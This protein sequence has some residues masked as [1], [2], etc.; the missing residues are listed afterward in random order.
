MHGSPPAL[1]HGAP[2]TAPR[3]DLCWV[4]PGDAP[5]AIAAGLVHGTV[6]AAYRFT[7]FRPSPSEPSRA[8][9]RAG[10]GARCVQRLASSS[11]HRETSR[12]AS[13]A[14]VVAE[15]QNRAR[16][17]GNRPPNDLTPT[18]LADYA[19]E[20]A[21]RHPAL[22]VSVLD[23][24]AIRELGMG[25]FAAVAQG[26]EQDARLITLR[27]AG[28]A[29]NARRLALVGKAVTFDSGGLSLKPPASMIE[30]KFDMCG[31]A[32]VI[33]AIGAL[34]DM[35][36]PVSVLGVVGATENMVSGRAVRPGD[37]V[38]ALDGTTIEMNN[39]DAE[40]RL[41]LGRLHHLRAT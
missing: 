24:R 6:L 41:V 27:Y 7:R 31:G 4:V 10:D 22:T 35:Q 40:G 30:M 29:A 26:S 12:A 37:I 3:E 34:A 14:A 36:A 39:I 2:V 9:G 28:A 16:E 1:V 38:T 32:A 17:L 13:R 8:R 33:E 21:A 15:A 11:A 25:A 19:V 5:D 20:L 23:G 18:A